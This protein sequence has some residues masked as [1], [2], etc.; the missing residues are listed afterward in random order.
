MT[1]CGFGTE[2]WT[3]VAPGLASHWGSISSF[4]EGEYH[5]AYGEDTYGDYSRP[6][7][8]D[9]WSD[10]NN[11][12][13][14]RAIALSL[15][16]ENQ[17][18]QKAIKNDARLE[19][20]E[21][22][23]KA[24]QGSLNINSSPQ[25]DH[26]NIFQPYLSFLPSEF[27]ICARSDYEIGRG[28]YL[29]CIG[30]HHL[31]ETRELCLSE[32]QTVSTILRRPRIGVVDKNQLCSRDDACMATPQWI[33]KSKPQ[34]KQSQFE[35]KFGQFFKHQIDSDVSVVYGDGFRR[36]TNA[37]RQGIVPLQ[38]KAGALLFFAAATKS[39]V[40][41]GPH[42][43]VTETMICNYEVTPCKHTTPLQGLSVGVLALQL[44]LELHRRFRPKEIGLTFTA[45]QEDGFQIYFSLVSQGGT[46]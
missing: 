20:D 30:H 34:G 39:L 24:L 16:E 32:E 31:P 36:G 15:S 7:L 43:H 46:L 37:A 4:S 5:G 27:G 18:R 42:A 10:D 33:S 14:H 41:I 28:R 23:A 44:R 26:G 25:Y 3:T 29:S 38:I 2:V 45:F 9:L 13:I 8:V 22:L 12:D 11:E 17:K 1:R 40:V 35:R 19:E 21:L 6:I